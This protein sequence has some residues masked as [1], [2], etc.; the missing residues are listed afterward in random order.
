MFMSTIPRTAREQKLLTDH[1]VLLI[2]SHKGPGKNRR[3]PDVLSIPE[4]QHRAE[5][6]TRVLKAILDFRPHPHWT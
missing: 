6:M 5:T 2:G 4:L 3:A 1:P